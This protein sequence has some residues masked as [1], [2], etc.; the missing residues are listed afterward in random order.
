MRASMPVRRF[1]LASDLDELGRQVDPGDAAA[2][3][4]REEPCRAADAAADV[5]H[6]LAGGQSGCLSEA[7]GR[8]AAEGVELLDRG[9]VVRVD[10]VDALPA[11]R[12]RGED[13]VEQAVDRVLS[14][15]LVHLPHRPV[16]VV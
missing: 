4:P 3:A 11:G 6:L 5:E 13:R 12:E 2:V 16:V 14:R 15:S 7:E 1:E 9:E 10:P 8:A